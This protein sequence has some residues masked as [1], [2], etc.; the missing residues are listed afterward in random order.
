M[1]IYRFKSTLH[2]VFKLNNMLL[3]KYF[4]DY[5]KRNCD[6]HSY[7]T[8]NK[9]NSIISRVKKKHVGSVLHRDV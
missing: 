7:Y 1:S 4:D 2:L 6:V 3:S 9:N 8:R 5:I